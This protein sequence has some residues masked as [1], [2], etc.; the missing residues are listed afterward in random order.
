MAPGGYLWWYV[1]ALSDDGQHGL[2]VIAFVGS[3][4]S[5]YY[6]RAR[7]HGGGDPENHVALNVVLYGLG[8]KRWAM[9]ERGRGA[10]DR[11]ARRLRIGPS[12]VAWE[13]GDL[14]LRFDE[15]TVPWP[16][17][18]RGELCLRPQGLA[19]Q[20][21]ALDA[22]GRHRWWPIAAR[23]EA[24]LDCSHPG[25]SWRGS[26]YL[27]SNQGDEPVAQAFSGWHWQR[28]ELADG[29]SLVLYDTQRLDGSEGALACLFGAGGSGAS[30]AQMLTEAPPRQ[31][32]PK[33]AWRVPREARADAGAALRCQTLEDTPFYARSLL[34]GQW[35]GQPG[36]AMHESLSLQRFSSPWVQAMLPFRM[37]RR[38]G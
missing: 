17:R 6:A 4:F 20:S 26:A 9:T 19:T 5:P 10:L 33:S 30:A 27:D 32:L 38:A 1:D 34:R 7:R 28:C 2:T 13:G 11:G 36:A 15:M 37:P 22:Q 14:V 21:H 18:L 31:A 3:V 35:L 24:R 16:S 23:A 25:L 12:Q 8:G 29:R